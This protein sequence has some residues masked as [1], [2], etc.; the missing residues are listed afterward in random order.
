MIARPSPAPWV[1]DPQT[2]TD[3]V[4]YQGASGDMNPIHH[5]QTYAEAAGYPSP[6]SVGMLQAGLLGTYATDW[7]GADRVRSFRTRF[8]EQVWP[9]DVLT[10]TGRVVREYE[11]DGVAMIDVELDCTRQTGG[12]AA[13]AWATFVAPE[14][15]S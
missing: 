1:I 13:T 11:Q 10:C 15:D 12:I 3:F 9:G 7:L 14:G 4:R 8:R 5:D 2:R 6:F